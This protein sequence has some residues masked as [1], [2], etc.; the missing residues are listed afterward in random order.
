MV[1][2]IP[3]H[4]ILAGLRPVFNYT[5]QRWRQ[6]VVSSLRLARLRKKHKELGGY[7]NE[8]AIWQAR[9]QRNPNGP[10][11]SAPQE[12]IVGPISY[13]MLPKTNKFKTNK[14]E[15]NREARQKMIEQSMAKMPKLIKQYREAERKRRQ[16][17]LQPLE[18][19]VPKFRFARSPDDKKGLAKNKKYQEY[20]AKLSKGSGAKKKKK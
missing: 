15:R 17:D 9:H 14:H 11:W 6:P 20:L 1:R 10:R 7:W 19:I 18:I 5:T 4:S 3:F 16:P 12:T 2:A 13:F 8:T